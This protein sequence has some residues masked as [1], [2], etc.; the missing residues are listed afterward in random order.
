MASVLVEAA[1][2]VQPLGRDVGRGVQRQP[3]H[4]ARDLGRRGAPPERDAARAFVEEGRHVA[5]AALYLGDERLG[6]PLQLGIHHA[7]RHAVDRDTVR[8]E[9]ERSRARDRIER[10]LA[11]RV[12]EIVGQRHARGGGCDVDDAPA[13]AVGGHVTPGGSDRQCR[14]AHVD[15]ERPVQG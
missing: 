6:A 7:R 8:G 2:D 9:R 10:R 3:H 11:R 14:R 1:G 15:L 13:P 12:G 4:H 5:S